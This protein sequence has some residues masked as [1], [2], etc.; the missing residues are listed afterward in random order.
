MDTNDIGQMMAK[1]TVDRDKL[2]K[3]IARINPNPIEGLRLPN[4]DIP[5]IEIPKPSPAARAMAAIAEGGLA[6]E[7]HKR[8]EEYCKAFDDRPDADHEIGVR[9]VSYGQT[10]ML[11]VDSIGYYNPSLIHFNGVLEDGKTPVQLIQHVSQINFVLMALPKKD[12]DKPKRTFGFGDHASADDGK[13]DEIVA[14]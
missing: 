8:L 10:I 13:K 11:Y 7:F 3:A 5:K 2:E 4:F 1:A 12:P 14:A 6:S 9:L